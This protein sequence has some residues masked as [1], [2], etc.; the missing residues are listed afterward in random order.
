MYRRVSIRNFRCFDQF[1]VTG[2]DR[3]NLFTGRNNSG[4]TTLLEAVF[5]LAGRGHAELPVRVNAWRGL[6]FSN[7]ALRNELREQLRLLFTNSRPED[8]IRIEGWTNNGQHDTLEITVGGSN[9]ALVRA[10]VDSH[11]SSTEAMSVTLL[12]LEF[13]RGGSGDAALRLHLTRNG[14]EA[15]RPFK[16]PFN[17]S[18]LTARSG[19]VDEDAR[20][21]SQLRRRKVGG[22]VL[23]AL[24]QIEPRLESIEESSAAGRSMI[25]GDVGLS[26][27]VPLPMMGEGM[28][29]VA[30]MLL[31]MSHCR[32]GILLIDEIENGIH[33]RAMPKV[34]TAL[35]AAARETDCQVLA[36]SHSYECVRT[37]VRSIDSDFVL[38][39]LQPGT[40]RPHVIYSPDEAR[41]AIR[42]GLEVR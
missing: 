3:I 39:R 16:T 42:L 8:A 4:K 2:L 17:A 24:Q 29:R 27:L 41:A 33:Y 7:Q 22:H 14:L 1:E 30:R 25:W 18:M 31:A 9:S 20:R 11:E 12:N 6:P 36:T 5:L 19:T 15:E 38:H 13:T 26:E 23:K 35:H 10:D 40:K 34:W 32:G 28:V 21:W 37:A